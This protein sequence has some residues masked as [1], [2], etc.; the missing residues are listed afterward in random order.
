L[1]IFSIVL[2]VSKNIYAGAK[3]SENQ[4]VVKICKMVVN[5]QTK[6]SPLS[7]IIFLFE[8]TARTARNLPVSASM[9]VKIFSLSDAFEN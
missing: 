3:K 6:F 9:A 7:V 5:L 1:C 8:K 4:M 2:C